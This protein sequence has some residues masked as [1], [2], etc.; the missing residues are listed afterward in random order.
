MVKK[1][2]NPQLKWPILWLILCLSNFACELFQGENF[3]IILETKNQKIVQKSFDFQNL[4]FSNLFKTF[5][6]LNFFLNFIKFSFIKVFLY[7]FNFQTCLDTLPM[8]TVADRTN[9]TCPKYF[10]I[11]QINGTLK[12]SMFSISFFFSRIFCVLQKWRVCY[13]QAVFCQICA[14]QTLNLEFEKN[15]K[16]Q[17]LI[18]TVCFQMSAYA[19]PT[20]LI[21]GEKHSFQNLIHNY[22]YNLRKFS[23][24]LPNIFFI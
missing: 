11:F 10:G 17:R 18:D 3:V 6:S 21:Y 23:R 8:C 22:A 14:F 4:L 13:P 1:S 20:Q 9:V 5:F 2:Q 15:R 19:Q 16:K 24:T 7:C 12:N